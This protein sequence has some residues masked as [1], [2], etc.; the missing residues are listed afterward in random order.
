MVKSKAEMQAKIDSIYWYH[1][2]N[3][4]DGLIAQTKI[5][6]PDTHRVLWAFIEA[7]LD[8]LSFEGKS[9]L[10][11]GCWDGYWSFYAE[12][13]GAREV[14]ATDDA[15]QHKGGDT[16]LRLAHQ[17]LQSKARVRSN[18]SVYDLSKLPAKFDV[19]FFLGLYYHLIDPMYALTELR[20][21]CH[22]ESVVVIEGDV[23]CHVHAGT[24]FLNRDLEVSPPRYGLS[25]HAIE[26]LIQAAYFRIEHSELCPMPFPE[27][28][29]GPVTHRG[30]FVCRPFEGKNDVFTLPPPFGLREYD[31]RWRKKLRWWRRG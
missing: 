17:L 22:A 31:P 13:R 7:E 10:D 4:G 21:K 18:I 3:F 23:L 27:G 5:P 6:N 12:R 16:G 19:I 30:L 8:R 2:F 15:T 24:I 26:T 9:V 1:E 28:Y 11:L 25:Q 20:K 29:T 14:W